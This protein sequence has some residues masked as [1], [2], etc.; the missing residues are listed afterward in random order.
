MGI[1][2]AYAAAL[3]SQS[4]KRVG[5]IRAPSS[6]TSVRNASGAPKYGTS[7]PAR[8]GCRP[9]PVTA[10]TPLLGDACSTPRPRDRS[11]GDNFEPM[12]PVRR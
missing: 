1:A 2:A 8:F 11:N 9:Y 6:G 10:F 4:S 5:M 12:R 7:A 3:P